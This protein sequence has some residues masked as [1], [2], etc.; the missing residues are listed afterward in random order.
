MSDIDV[1]SPESTTHSG[2]R[3][4]VGRMEKGLPTILIADDDASLLVT[5]SMLLTASGYSVEATTS[6]P[7]TLDRWPRSHPDLVIVD[8]HMP[9]SG[10]GLVRAITKDTSVPVIVLSAD[11]QEDVK[12]S[13]L[14]AGAEDYITK[15]FSAAELLARVRVALRRVVRLQEEVEIGP[16]TLSTQSQSMEANGRT[17]PLTPTEFDLLRTLASSTGFV[18]TSHL[19][20]QVWGPAYQTEHEY[21]RTYMRRIRSK[22]ETMGLVDMIESRPGRG[23]RLRA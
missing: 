6:G 23:Y 2:L 16:L 19:L 3:S 17:I 14:D 11:H 9:G 4:I 18:S 10:V 12:I 8:L 13:A 7:E 22:L 1:P 5:I 15:P 21:V 20:A